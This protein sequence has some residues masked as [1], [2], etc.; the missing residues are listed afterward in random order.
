MVSNPT[1]DKIGITSE[2]MR[3]FIKLLKKVEENP[4]Q[5]VDFAAPGEDLRLEGGKAN[6]VPLQ[7]IPPESRAHIKLQSDNFQT[8]PLAKLVRTVQA[9]KHFHR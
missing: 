3:F 2:Q 1:T 8:T 5:I 6:A 7:Q 9:T 4:D